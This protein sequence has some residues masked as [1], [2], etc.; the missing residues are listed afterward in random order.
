MTRTFHGPY[1]FRSVLFTPGHNEKYIRSAYRSETDCVVLD[2]EDAVPEERKQDAREKIREVLE[3][4]IIDERPVFVRINPMDTGH[5]LVD[6]DSVACR[7]LTGFVYPKAYTANDIKAFSAQLALKE[8][9]LGLE[10]GHFDVIVLMETP[11]AVLEA[12]PIAMASPRVVALLYGCEDFLTDMRGSHGLG[13]RSL[14]VPRHLVSMA[15]RAAG[16][17]PIDTPFVQ[18]HDI[19]GLREHI[20]QARELGYEG[21]LTMSP[22]QVS[23][24]TEMYTPSA[25]EIDEA[26]QIVAAAE[27]AKRDDRGISL[28]KNLFVSPPTLRRA[29][30]LLARQADI[31]TFESRRRDER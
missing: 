5:T 9:T 17:V 18:V 1:I 21:M 26:E 2:L 31:E 3:S 24:A 8:M 19:E 29:R 13:G 15:A 11:Q 12:L 10:K 7:H 28:H 16:V 4:D 23:M 6:L 20:E 30:D 27:A 22:R 14:L 25:A